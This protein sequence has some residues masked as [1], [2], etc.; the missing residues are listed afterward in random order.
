M[1]T[2]DLFMAWQDNVKTVARFAFRA[3]EWF[4]NSMVE[5]QARQEQEQMRRQG[6]PRGDDLPKLTW[7]DLG[8]LADENWRGIR[9]V[10]VYGLML[11]GSVVYIGRAIYKQGLHWRLQQ[12]YSGKAAGG[13]TPSAQ[14]IH[15]TRESI[16]VSVVRCQDP[17]QAS[18]VE[19]FLI[20]K[21]KPPWNELQPIA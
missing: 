9:E 21:Y 4:I 3:G 1:T 6:V 12:Y 13:K 19:A 15:E 5:N 16:R 17:A 8:T 18:R 14:K 2:R 7:E 20:N 11:D 10:G